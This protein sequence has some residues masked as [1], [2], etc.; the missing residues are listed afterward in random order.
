VTLANT[1]QLLRVLIGEIR[2]VSPTDIKPTYRVPVP[3]VRFDLTLNDPDSLAWSAA[4]IP[5]S[6]K[7][8]RP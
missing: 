3:G 2:V 8:C 6:E 1:R 7:A 5:W 4:L